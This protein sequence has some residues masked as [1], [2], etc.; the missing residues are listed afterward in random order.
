MDA[1]VLCLIN[2]QRTRRGLPRLVEASRLVASAQHWSDWMVGAGRFTHGLNFAARISA[3]GF[4]YRTAGEN[5]G[6]GLRTPLATVN[7][8]MRSADHCR[9]ILTPTFRNAGTGVS[10]HPVRGW[11]SSPATWT[12]DFGLS[13]FQAAPS[14]NWG[15]ADGCPY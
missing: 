6:T 15:P 14:R 9:N 7:A 11:S 4:H 13:M 12:E 3:A 10:P 2:E 1:A 5:I 8:W